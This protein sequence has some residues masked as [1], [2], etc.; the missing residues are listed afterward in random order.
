MANEAGAG[1]NDLHS[2]HPIQIPNKTLDTAVKS[3]VNHWWGC[4]VFPFGMPSLD[5]QQIQRLSVMVG[6]TG[7][8]YDWSQYSG[9]D[10]AAEKMLSSLNCSFWR[11]QKV[12][13][14]A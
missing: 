5:R 2:V 4:L 9:N 6:S 7:F 10:E 11:G 8:T 1:E 12:K 14:C 3:S 13:L